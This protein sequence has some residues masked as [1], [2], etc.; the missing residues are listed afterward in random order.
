VKGQEAKMS[1]PVFGASINTPLF[2]CRQIH[3]PVTYWRVDG[4]EHRISQNEE[5]IIPK[6]FGWL[7][8]WL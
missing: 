1:F 6:S 5:N 4:M 3:A 7:S 8:Q 2:D